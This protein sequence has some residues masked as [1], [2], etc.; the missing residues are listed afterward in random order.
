M[1]SQLPHSGTDMFVAGRSPPQR[2]RSWAPS[3]RWQPT[4]TST[5]CSPWCGGGYIRIVYMDVSR[6]AYEA[7]GVYEQSAQRALLWA[8]KEEGVQKTTGDQRN[9]H[10]LQVWVSRE[11]R[12]KR[13]HMSLLAGRVWTV[14][15]GGSHY[16]HGLCC[17]GQLPRSL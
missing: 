11:G 4:A 10:R 9:C 3:S 7:C 2:R 13:A 5:Q 8:A 6:R 12:L 16:Y 17:S 1:K 15:I 14:R